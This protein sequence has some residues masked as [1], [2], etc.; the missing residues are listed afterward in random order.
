MIPSILFNVTHFINFSV[1]EKIK[2][3][4]CNILYRFFNSQAAADRISYTDT[5]ISRHF[6]YYLTLMM[7]YLLNCNN[8]VSL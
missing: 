7:H 4:V 1:T 8:L 3:S 5:V 6:K 2:F